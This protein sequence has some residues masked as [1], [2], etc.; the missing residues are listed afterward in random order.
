MGEAV[1]YSCFL[2]PL[3][4]VT[5]VEQSA[6]SQATQNAGGVVMTRE[7]NSYDQQIRSRDAGSSS[8]AEM[9][10]NCRI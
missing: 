10:T 2:L 7:R 1:S 9:N 4:V 3:A 8:S 6:I 5:Q